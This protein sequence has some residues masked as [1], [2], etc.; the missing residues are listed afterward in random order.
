[1]AT[2]LTPPPSTLQPTPPPGAQPQAQTPTPPP[3][4]SPTRPPQ[5]APSGGAGDKPD[6]KHALLSMIPFV[7]AQLHQEHLI[8]LQNQHEAN[9]HQAD[10][11]EHLATMAQDEKTR[12]AMLQAAY[13]IRS[14][15]K[16]P[17]DLDLNS[18]LNRLTTQKNATPPPSGP[19]AHEQV[20][21]TGQQAAAAT[22]AQSGLT[23]P[24]GGSNPAASPASPGPQAVTPTPP[25]GSPAAASVSAGQQNAATPPPTVPPANQQQQLGGGSTPGTP[26]GGFSVGPV[27]GVPT[28]SS[29]GPGQLP[30]DLQFKGMIEGQQAS[31]EI[32]KLHATNEEQLRIMREQMGMLTQGGNGGSGHQHFTWETGP[33]GMSMKP[34]LGRSTPGLMIGPDNKPY[35]EIRYAD[36][37][38]ENKVEDTVARYETAQGPD[39]QPHVFAIDRAGNNLGE[40]QGMTPYPPAA[41]T[42]QVT[43]TG[44]WQYVNTGNGLQKVWVSGS[45]T[46]QNILPNAASPTAPPSGSGSAAVSLAAPAV[47]SPTPPPGH[48]KPTAPRASAPGTSSAGDPISAPGF[49]EK[50][51]T[52]K[53][54]TDYTAK[55]RNIENTLDLANR[56]SAGLPILNSLIDAKKIELQADPKQGFVKALINRTV[57]LSPQEAELAGDFTSLMEHINTLRAPLG[58][59]GFRSEEA[60]EA[61]QAQ[62]GSLMAN[63]EVTRAVLRNTIRALT[64]NRDAIAEGLNKGPKVGN[65]RTS[66]QP[67]PPPGRANSSRPSLE[68]LIPSR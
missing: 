31:T 32:A 35:R 52:P 15:N 11:Y 18:V 12:D 8:N 43:N 6:W 30:T 68:E 40:V 55:L 54:A 39:G 34:D 51:L 56:V 9:A 1:M 41:F 62:R 10:V 3:S 4:S 48:A 33:H 28:P 13:Q 23:P 22:A 21:A 17:K 45:T 65:A 47:S 7:G 66:T 16:V 20:S 49:I 60:F 27:A 29:L 2:T 19:S 42:P 46:K 25:P 58:A 64:V 38:T 53:E 59:T 67:T 57:P 37:T 14:T 5:F 63:P 61:L 44:H 26:G 36:G 50:G 24:P